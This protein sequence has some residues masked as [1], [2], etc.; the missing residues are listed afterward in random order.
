MTLNEFIKTV[1]EHLN[2]ID[3]STEMFHLCDRL[4]NLVEKLSDGK[5]TMNFS[6]YKCTYGY[7]T[8]VEYKT[9]LASVDIKKRKCDTQGDWIY[10]WTNYTIKAVILSKDCDGNETIENLLNGAKLEREKRDNAKLD[11]EKALIDF[12][13]NY[14]FASMETIKDVENFKRELLS[15]HSIFSRLNRFYE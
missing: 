8:S 6:D 3:K 15:N 7:I 1:N 13:K 12:L 14:D 10:S 11:K 9:I 2:E 5:I 4:Q